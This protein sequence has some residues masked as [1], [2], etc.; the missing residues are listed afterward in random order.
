MTTGARVAATSSAGEF[1]SIPLLG[2]VARGSLVQLRWPT[3]GDLDLITHLRNS[4]P[5]RRW[6]IDDRELD[7]VA[8]RRWLTD[9]SRRPSEGL[10]SIALL[11][12][13]RWLGTIGW[14][15]WNPRT[16]EAEFG[17]LMVCTAQL[18]ASRAND[19]IHDLSPM[20]DAAVALRRLA[21]GEMNLRRVLARVL[22]QNA[23]ALHFAK[24]LGFAIMGQALVQRPSDTASLA[25]VNLELTRETYLHSFPNDLGRGQP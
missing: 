4:Q 23:Q 22:A 8:N 9:A 19:E 13:A 17:R 14:S 15:N 2:E 3:D 1:P 20:L 6:F 12:S 25:V 10:L 16:Q 21:F 18:A 7:P 5:V 24:E 11:S